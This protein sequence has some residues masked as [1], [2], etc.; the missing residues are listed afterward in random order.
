MVPPLKPLVRVDPLRVRRDVN[1]VLEAIAEALRVR[2]KAQSANDV[3]A[4]KLDVPAEVVN[5]N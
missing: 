5:G 2:G 3:I 1:G 4:L